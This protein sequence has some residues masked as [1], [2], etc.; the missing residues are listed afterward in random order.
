M[1]ARAEVGLWLLQRASAGVLA[2]CVAIHLCTIIVAM[3]QGLSAAA[4][5]DRTHGNL[6]WAVFYAVFVVAVSIH[7]PIGLRTI[8]REWLGW[9]GVRSDA[10]F[11]IV[12]LALLALGAYAIVAVI[13]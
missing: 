4:I 3:H 9:R 1:T 2:V 12:G 11:A 5:L 7:A 6:A 10:A 13:R 8:A